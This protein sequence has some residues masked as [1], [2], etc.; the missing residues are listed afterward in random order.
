MSLNETSAEKTIAEDNNESL[1]TSHSGIVITVTSAMGGTGKSTI[2]TL[3]ASQ[4]FKSSQKA[5]DEREMERPL[6]ACVVDLDVFDGQLGFLLGVD[7]P[8]SLDIALSNE[9]LDAELVFNNLVYSP[10]MGFHAL[11]TPVNG[12]TGLNTG[13]VFYRKVINILRT[14]F[15]VVILDISYQEQT[16]AINRV[17]LADSDAI[18]LATTLSIGSLKS[19]QEW[20]KA[21]SNTEKDFGYDIDI[22][23]VGIVIN[24]SIKTDA[25]TT[26]IL[27]ELIPKTPKIVAI[28]M[29]TVAVQSAGNHQRLDTLLESHPLIGPAYFSLADKI[30]KKLD[31]GV[32]VKLSTLIDDKENNTS[33]KESKE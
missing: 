25:V 3:L 19:T 8:T 31:I 30:T 16:N 28:P 18:L 32:E 27:Q 17:A 5:V 1:D 7:G 23:K 4:L 13:S 21:V 26:E 33:D 11:L 10:Q 6:K 20:I 2:S 14:L 22:K 24:Q 9:T 12:I 15:D 29:D